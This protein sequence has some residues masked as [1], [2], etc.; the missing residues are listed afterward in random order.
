ML[1]YC[2]SCFCCFPVPHIKLTT[3]T[4]RHFRNGR[5]QVTDDPKDAPNQ[6]LE[7]IHVGRIYNTNQFVSDPKSL[8]LR[9]KL[10]EAEHLSK[11]KHVWCI[12]LCYNSHRFDDGDR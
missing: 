4:K 3:Q 8:T 7:V 6:K 9:L 1:P 5:Q 11:A 2:S 12:S 10:Q